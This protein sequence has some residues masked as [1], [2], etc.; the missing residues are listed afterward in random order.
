MQ[1]FAGHVYNFIV[2]SFISSCLPFLP[3]CCQISEISFFIFCPAVM[4]QHFWLPTLFF[5]SSLKIVSHSHKGDS[6]GA[7]LVNVLLTC[8][9]MVFSCFR[10]LL[11]STPFLELC[12]PVREWPKCFHQQCRRTSAIS[13]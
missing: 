1:G 8:N 7:A 10:S 2:R 3:L 5:L 6:K 12:Y 4:T 9:P 11:F 13:V